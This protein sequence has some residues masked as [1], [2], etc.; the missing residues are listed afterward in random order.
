MAF[1]A[2][3]RIT[4]ALL[5][6]NLHQLQTQLTALRFL[7]DAV[8][9]QGG[10]LVQATGRDVR[11]RPAQHILITLGGRRYQR[12]RYWRSYHN[13]RNHWLWL[14]LWLWRWSGGRCSGE[15][16][17]RWRNIQFVEAALRQVAVKGQILPF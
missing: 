6:V 3:E 16:C 4:V 10:S 13:R 14:W 12:C 11:L 15:F 17:A 5:S 8:F 2:H 1:L 9:Q 7:L